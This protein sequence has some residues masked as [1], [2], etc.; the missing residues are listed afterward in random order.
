MPEYSKEMRDRIDARFLKKTKSRFD[1]AKAMAEFRASR[2]AAKAVTP[3]VRQS[4]APKEKTEGNTLPAKDD[5][6][7][8]IKL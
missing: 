6:P 2:A 1:G 7:S 5:A 3:R 4:W 8:A